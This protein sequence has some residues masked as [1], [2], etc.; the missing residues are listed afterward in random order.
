M[1]TRSIRRGKRNEGD[2]EFGLTDAAF[3]GLVFFLLLVW[4]RRNEARDD[5]QLPFASLICFCK[6]WLG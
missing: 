1:I 3:G 2:L 5:A 6:Y 4:D